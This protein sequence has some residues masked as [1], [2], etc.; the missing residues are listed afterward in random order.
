VILSGR[1]IDIH[2]N[3]EFVGFDYNVANRQLTLTWI[4]SAG[5]WVPENEFKR[6]TF[7]HNN[8][9]FLTITQKDESDDPSDNTCL[10]EVT[11]FPSTQR[12]ITDSFLTQKKPNQD[13][14]IL[15]F[16]QNG[17]TIRICSEEIYL[18]IHQ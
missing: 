5:N 16:F 18:M 3:F 8:I 11:F 1:L 12:D 9:S 4:K 6:L 2:N 14:D 15:Y 17:Q 10:S 13:D 7:S